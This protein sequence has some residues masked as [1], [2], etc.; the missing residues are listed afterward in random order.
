MSLAYKGEK[1]MKKFLLFVW[2]LFHDAKDHF[3]DGLF[4]I[5][6][7]IVRRFS[8]KPEILSVDETI[9]YILNNQCSVSRFGDGEIRLAAGVDISFQVS[10]REI[11]QQ[12]RQV[13]RS[14]EPGLLIC[15]PSAFEK[16]D[17]MT[18]DTKKYWKKHMARYRCE[19]CRYLHKGQTYGNAF[20]SRNYMCF[21]DKNNASD[22]FNSLKRLWDNRNIVFVE[23]EKSRLGIGNDLFDNARSIRRI[24]GPSTYAFKKYTQLLDEANKLEK[25]CLI[26]LAL[27]PVA[28][29]LA[30]DL[31]KLG[32]QALD[33]GHVDI[34]YEWFLKGATEKQP[35]ANKMVMEAGAGAGVGDLNDKQYLSQV[36]SRVL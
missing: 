15:L 6:D 33:M 22:Y 21:V 2:N 26:I 23:G 12:L 29:V 28:T 31:N 9:A 20:I 19:W 16:L 27:G 14:D 13:L 8:F 25:S 32:Y 35:V 11:R 5:K 36:I 1:I 18:I 34:E 10:T 3:V 4:L 30:Y 24:L 17:H 7:F